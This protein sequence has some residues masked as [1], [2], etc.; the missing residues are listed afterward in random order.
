[1]NII[2][3]MRAERIAKAG[4]KKMAQDGRYTF[5]QDTIS[6]ST[7]VVTNPEGVNYVVCPQEGVLAFCSCPFAKENRI[8][9]H[10][11][12]LRYELAH[13]AADVARWEAEAEAREEFETFGRYL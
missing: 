9:K 10:Q 2:D 6:P 13:E 1:M 11:V 4:A 12:W 5:A 3:T 7:Y 8:C